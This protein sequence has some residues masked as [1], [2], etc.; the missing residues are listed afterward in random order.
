MN[1]KDEIYL[2][3]KEYFFLDKKNLNRKGYL[4]DTENPITHKEW[5]MIQWP[6]QASWH[7]LNDLVSI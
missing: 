5:L 3:H 1:L 2:F 6:D 7:S 4:I